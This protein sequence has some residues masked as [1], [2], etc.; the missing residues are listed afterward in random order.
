MTL[1]EFMDY[2]EEL[3]ID[4]PALLDLDLNGFIINGLSDAPIEVKLAVA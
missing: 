4:N 2:V 3:A 1:G